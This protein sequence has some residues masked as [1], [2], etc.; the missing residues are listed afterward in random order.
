[1]SVY[2]LQ[3]IVR[4]AHLFSSHI[5][6]PQIYA[7]RFSFRKIV[8]RVCGKDRWKYKTFT[9]ST[10]G[11]CIQVTRNRPRFF[12]LFLSCN[13]G[14]DLLSS[15]YG[16]KNAQKITMK[17]LMTKA[18]LVFLKMQKSSPRAKTFSRFDVNFPD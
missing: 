14:K 4:K 16:A 12:L 2:T 10:E 3:S 9:F 6:V 18:A 11:E 15:N 7:T 13:R 5:I 8:I 1:M 17:H